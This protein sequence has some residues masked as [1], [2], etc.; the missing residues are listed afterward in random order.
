MLKHSL[1]TIQSPTPSL[2][3]LSIIHKSSAS[4]LKVM[5]FWWKKRKSKQKIISIAWISSDLTNFLSF[6]S[7]RISSLVS[8]GHHSSEQNNPILKGSTK[9][10]KPCWSDYEVSLS[11]TSFSFYYATKFCFCLRKTEHLQFHSPLCFPSLHW[12]IMCTGLVGWSQRT[13]RS[14]GIKTV[15]SNWSFPKR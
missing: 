8:F 14:L 15:S 1:G 7:Q 11:A 12:Q 13:L 2:L 5:I 10:F 3:L 4:L 6:W 9:L